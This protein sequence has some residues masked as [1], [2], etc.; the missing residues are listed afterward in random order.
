MCPCLR[1]AEPGG[2]K[3]TVG[4][5][6]GALCVVLALLGL[7][8]LLTYLKRS[9]ACC[10]SF[11]VPTLLLH[12][13]VVRCAV[14]PGPCCFC[15]AF[16]PVFFRLRVLISW[17]LRSLLL[18]HSQ[19]RP[20]RAPAGYGLPGPGFAPLSDGPAPGGQVPGLMMAPIGGAP[21]TLQEGRVQ[22]GGGGSG[23]EPSAPPP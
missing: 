5:I 20:P 18:D 19:W 23:S 6:L 21:F 11:P 4:A 1:A 2:S 17:S 9:K 10:V 12:A 14:L 7:G 3:P 22:P 16:N 13:F 15:A 8:F